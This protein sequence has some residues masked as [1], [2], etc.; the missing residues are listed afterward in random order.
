MDSRKLA[1]LCRDLAENKKAEDVVVLDL[2]KLSTVTD[3]FVIATGTSE[4]H[5][6]AVLDEIT[7][8]VG[9][10][11]EV[12]PRIEG[13]VQTGWVVLDYFEV[14]VHLMR[15]EMRERYDLEG[16]WGDAPRVK[17]KAVKSAK[18]AAR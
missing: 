5:L 8:N 7:D 15:A 6:R 3:F 17:P 14:M 16:L 18:Q 11:L 2:R 4:P 9:D 13:R 12:R 10:K 1:L